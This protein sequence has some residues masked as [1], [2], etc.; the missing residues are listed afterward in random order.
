MTA[1][2]L[3]LTAATGTT[4]L[5]FSD[6]AVETSED[7][8]IVAS[9]GGVIYDCCG[10][11]LQHFCQQVPQRF[12]QYFLQFS[13][14]PIFEIELLAALL[15]LHTWQDFLRDSY[16]VLYIDNES[17]RGALIKAYSTVDTANRIITEFADLE[18]RN[19]IKIWVGRVPFH[20]NPA[21]EPSRLQMDRRA[22]LGSRL[23]NPSWDFADRCTS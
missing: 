8:T 7:D 20:S 10:K 9:V 14:H 4:F 13:S 16:T 21:D 19:Q 3:T 1:P 22:N 11:P 12:L 6:G 23:V 2:P 15:S 5:V 18:M 17:A